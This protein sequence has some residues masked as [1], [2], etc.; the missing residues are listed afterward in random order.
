MVKN[1][2]LI[3]FG[4]GCLLHAATFLNLRTCQDKLQKSEE[5]LERLQVDYNDLFV[6]AS[7]RGYITFHLNPPIIS[8]WVE[9][10]EEALSRLSKIPTNDK[11]LTVHGS[12]K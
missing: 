6:G 10:K 7:Q 3:I 1:L 2:M 12:L 4:T 9:T 8:D 11:D 5:K